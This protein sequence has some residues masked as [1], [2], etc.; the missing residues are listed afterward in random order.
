MTANATPATSNVPAN[1]SAPAA[2]PN[3]LTARLATAYEDSAAKVKQLE[4]E[5][6]QVKD[7][8][9]AQ[10][11]KVGDQIKTLEDEITALKQESAALEAQIPVRTDV[12]NT[13]IAA[14]QVKLNFLTAKAKEIN[15]TR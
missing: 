8:V 2:N 12:I 1:S 6:K 7:E 14:E 11:A 10:V 4:A 3:S 5:A 9:F 13:L 15:P